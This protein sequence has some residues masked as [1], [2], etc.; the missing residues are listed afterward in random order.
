M[1]NLTHTLVGIALGQAGFN[2]KTRYATWAMAIGSNL[3]DADIVAAWHGGVNYLRYHRGITHSLIG[4]TVLGWAL[5]LLFYLFGRRAR[6][7]P[8]VPPINLKWLIAACWFSTA[9]H[10]FMDYTNQYGVRP[11]LPFSGRWFALDIMPIVGPWLLLILVLGLGLPVLFRIVSEE[12]GAQTKNPR[13]GQRGAIIALC[14]MALLWGMRG[15]SHGRAAGMLESHLYGGEAADRIGA[16]PS[17][18]NPFDWTGVVETDAAFYM[19]PVN[20]LDSDVDLDQERVF[21]KPK[22]SPP[23]VAAQHT[24]TAKVFLNFARFPWAQLDEGAETDEVTIRDLRFASLGSR[25]SGFMVEVVLDKNLK[26]LKQFFTFGGQ[27]RAS[28]Q[29]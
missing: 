1:D 19:L 15:L 4:V 14:G 18:I 27:S 10:L 2:R 25:R 7:K 11:F 3:P 8:N 20:A 6:Q 28:S 5:A 24:D 9:L 23:I 22:A 13:A 16:F 26:V 17:L 12:V 29:P 21:R